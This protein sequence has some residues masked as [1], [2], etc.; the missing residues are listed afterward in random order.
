LYRS[1]A[2]L[3]DAWWALL[4][5]EPPFFSIPVKRFLSFTGKCATCDSLL[6]PCSA[7]FSFT[8]KL[9]YLRQASY[10]L[11]AIGIEITKYRFENQIH[12]GTLF[13]D[14]FRASSLWSIVSS[15]VP[16]ASAVRYDTVI[17]SLLWLLCFPL[18]CQQTWCCSCW[19]CAVEDRKSILDTH[20]LDDLRDPLTC[21]SDSDRLRSVEQF[22]CSLI[23][24]VV[25][26][27]SAIDH[28]LQ[29]FLMYYSSVKLSLAIDCE[30]FASINRIN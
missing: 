25:W 14:A 27:S 13:R 18:S 29:Y 8:G 3:F 26:S 2:L 30:P 19:V 1:S 24:F 4:F 6:L 10:V 23:H 11:S 22:G 7:F 12:N 28:R 15:L 5:D 9:C 20:S 16:T 21:W 17:Q